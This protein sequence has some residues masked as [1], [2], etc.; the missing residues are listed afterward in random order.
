MCPIVLWIDD[1]QWGD[2]DSAELLTELLRGPVLPRLMLL[3]SYR[4]E[5]ESMNPCLKTISQ[6]ERFVGGGALV[7][8]VAVGPLA[9]NDALGLAATLLEDAALHDPAHVASI[10]RESAGNPYLITEIARYVQAASLHQEAGVAADGPIGVQDMVW[11]RIQRLP[12]ESRRLLE[13][14]AVAG[15][16]LSQRCAYVPSGVDVKDHSAILLLRTER[17]LRSTG[18]GVDD[19]VEVYHDQIRECLLDRLSAKTKCEH[20][21]RLAETLEARGGADPETLAFHFASGDQPSRAGRYYRKAAIQADRALAFDRAATL[22]RRA[23][24]LTDWPMPMEAQ[25]KAELGNALANS[26]RGR[27]AGRAYL[28]AAVVPQSRSQS[29]ELRRAH[30]SSFSPRANTIAASRSSE[31]SL[32]QSGCVIRQHR[33]G[34]SCRPPWAWRESG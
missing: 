13:V 34:H 15:R 28:D 12:E 7:A 9:P 32:R 6:P 22:Y 3:A 19:E 1:V 25:I 18:P 30:F 5:Y 33:Q 11:L 2:L 17:L 4:S 23:L 16:P 31:E 10:A 29:I 26:R 24:E 27:E 20:H 14:I 8:R 21:G